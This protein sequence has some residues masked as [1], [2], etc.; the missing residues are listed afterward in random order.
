MLRLGRD[1]RGHRRHRAVIQLARL[2]PR[3]EPVEEQRLLAE[4]ALGPDGGGRA[5]AAALG[6]RLPR[7]ELQ[8]HLG[9]DGGDVADEGVHHL[10]GVVRRGRHPQ[11]LLAP[12]HRRVVDRLHVVA[13]APDQ[14]IGNLGAD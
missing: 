8:P 6:G 9:P 5:G 14:V 2:D 3:L 11:H 13:V 7:P 4:L 1:G 12:R 10:L